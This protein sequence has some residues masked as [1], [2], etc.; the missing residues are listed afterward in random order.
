MTSF[1]TPQQLSD[2][3][4]CARLS[5]MLATY[6]PP[7]WPVR[8]ALA[9]YLERGVGMLAGGAAP[10]D[11]AAEIATL[12][13]DEAGARGFESVIPNYRLDRN[14]YVLMRDYACWLE[15]AAS[16]VGG[17][18]L[19]LA[20]AAPIALAGEDL[21]LVPSAWVETGDHTAA[22]VFR[23]SERA[24][25]ADDPRIHWPELVASLL[26]GVVTVILHTLLLPAPSK[27]RIPSPLV[28]AYSHPMTGHLR[29]ATLD[30]EGA[31]FSPAW[32]RVA[33]WELDSTDAA[34]LWPEWR[35]GIERDRCLGRCYVETR[36]EFGERGKEGRRELER[37]IVQIA[38]A[39]ARTPEAARKREA[40]PRCMMR[41]LCHGDKEERESY[42]VI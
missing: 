30:H 14:L 7:S 38:A 5:Q 17:L 16:L 24:P 2:W 32:K 29:L 21:A 20:P 34:I 9:R 22:H 25:D 11:T 18:R 6:E 33:R 27:D 8:R 13:L 42:R 41:G 26:P 40:C 28:L 35:A 10:S 15:G 36:Y 39:M 23:V 31:R 3:E 37:D 1:L 12:F 4:F 19:E